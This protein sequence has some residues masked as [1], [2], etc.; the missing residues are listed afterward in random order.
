MNFLV[1]AKCTK[2]LGSA[3]GKTMQEARDKLNHAVG[4]TRGIKCGDNYNCVVEIKS[5]KPVEKKIEPKAET[6]EET[7]EETKE[8]PKIF[9]P[10]EKPKKSKHKE[11]YR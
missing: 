3:E 2:C 6:I 4:L 5:S 8:T 1:K 11:S 10:A 9:T 7:K